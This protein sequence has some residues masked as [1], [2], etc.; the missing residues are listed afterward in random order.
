MSGTISARRNPA[1][2]AEFLA[3]AMSHAVTPPSLADKAVSSCAITN[4][5]LVLAST[6]NPL[7]ICIVSISPRGMSE[8]PRYSATA[9]SRLLMRCAAASEEKHASQ[10]GLRHETLRR[11]SSTSMSVKCSSLWMIR[12]FR[13]GAL[14]WTCRLRIGSSLRIWFSS[15]TAH[16]LML[17]QDFPDA[18]NDHN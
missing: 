14:L 9:P 6:L 1:A 10:R 7:R 8:W 13:P 17:G 18:F 12:A 2:F 15:C 16:L 11:Q 4:S 3:L 5:F